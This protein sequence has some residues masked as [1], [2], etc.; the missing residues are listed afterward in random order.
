VREY[1][2]QLVKDQTVLLEEIKNL[3]AK[4]NIALP[5]TVTPQKEKGRENLA[6]KQG[7][8]FDDAFIKTIAIDQRID[9]RLFKNATEFS[10]KE[11]SDFAKKYLPLMQA[12]LAK[13]NTFKPSRK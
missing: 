4:R 10:D 9:V 1:A 13:T 11:V 6:K 7:K 8:T 3:A 12:H 5:A 2:V